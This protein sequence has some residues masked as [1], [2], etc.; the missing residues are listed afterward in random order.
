MASFQVR[1]ENIIG[2]VPNLGSDDA[3][4]TQVAI[5]DALTD[6]TASII[7]VI[8]PDLLWIMGTETTAVTTNPLA[9][10]PIT[11]SK[12]IKVERENG[13]D[14]HG[15]YVSCTSA[16]PFLLSQMQDPNSIHY[17][18]KESPVWVL[19]NDTVY[20]FPAPAVSNQARYVYIVY[21]SVTYDD[22][23]VDTPFIAELD[24]V[25]VLG[26]CVKLKQRQIAFF[27]DDEDPE[28]VQANKIQLDDLLARYKDA[29][30][31][32]VAPQ[33]GA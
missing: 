13:D 8:N 18:S 23:S 12:I 4:A 2:A 7:D 1:I 29:L 30:A 28:N 5:T 25:V 33:P 31:P 9:T 16:S 21:P 27:I 14:I 17:P 24:Q 3:T 26:A 22:T 20:V 19:D 15:A 6:A 11:I 10:S 32:Y